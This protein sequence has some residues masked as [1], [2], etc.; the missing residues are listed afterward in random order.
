M[1][2]FDYNVAVVYAPED[3]ESLAKKREYLFKNCDNITPVDCE[4]LWPFLKCASDDNYQNPFV[5][6][7]DYSDTIYVQFPYDPVKYNKII[8]EII[9]IATGLSIDPATVLTTEIGTDAN[10]TTFLNI[11]INTLNAPDCFY[12]T[13][14]WFA[15]VP[16]VGDYN[17]CYAAKILAGIPAW[18]AELECYQT[19][20]VGNEFAIQ[21]EPFRRV[22][23]EGTILIHG[24]Y[25][26]YDCNGQ[27][28]GKFVT[29]SATNSFIPQVRV[30]G[31]IFWKG[32]KVEET[33][34]NRERI[35]SRRIDTYKLRTVKVPPSVVQI[36]AQCFNAK[37]FFVDANSYKGSLTLDKNFEEGKMWIIDTDVFIECP[38][39][40]FSCDV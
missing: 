30:M 18:R 15:C 29:G 24:F 36:I 5:S 35:R 12:F 20:C 11:L 33:I 26:K 23:C 14:H 39:I 27:Y 17:T 6:G 28:Y 40:D 3:N 9:D 21:S 16:D 1:Q 38:E 10:G 2:N 19:L 31:E 8:I 4:Q 32:D 22:K 13:T 34:V 7:P 37:L 25:P